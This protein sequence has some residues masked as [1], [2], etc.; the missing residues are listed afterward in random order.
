MLAKSYKELERKMAHMPTPPKSPEEYCVDC[1]H[2]MFEPDIEINRRMHAKGFTQDQAQEAYNLAAEKMV[3]MMHEM[4]ADFKADRE[5]ERLINHF[6]GAGQW[7]EVSRQLLSFG[8]KNLPH[9]VL[10]NLSSS[11]EGVLA[12]Y[13]MMKGGEPGLK[14]GGSP[15]SSKLDEAALNAMKVTQGFE[16]LYGE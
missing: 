7:T 1:Q 5:V 9:D 2:G 16:G 12:L 6:G 8:Q 4:A 10:D 15:V 3:P 13:R 14:R 11:Y